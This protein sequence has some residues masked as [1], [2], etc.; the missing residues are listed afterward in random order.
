MVVVLFIEYW[1]EKC[2][3]VFST[4]EIFFPI[5]FESTDV[6]PTDMGGWLYIEES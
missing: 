1:Q 5:I 6:K 4:D 2:L 3:Y